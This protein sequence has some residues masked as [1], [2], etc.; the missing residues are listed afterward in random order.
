MVC[1]HNAW[2]PEQD[3]P[4]GQNSLPARMNLIELFALDQAAFKQRFKDAPMERTKRK[5]LL[6]NAAIVLG[7]QKAKA[8]LPALRQALENETDEGM[9]D[10]CRWAIHQI[11]SA[12]DITVQEKG[13]L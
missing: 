2:T 9:L 8:A 11:E 7:N 12:S 10:A 5:G 4:L 13:S 6:R 1:P 3:Y